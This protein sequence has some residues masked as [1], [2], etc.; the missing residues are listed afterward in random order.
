MCMRAPCV[1]PEG[2]LF[3]LVEREANRRIILAGVPLF[4]YTLDNIEGEIDQRDAVC[5][6]EL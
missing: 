1:L 4:W 6:V 5:A 2:N 3:T